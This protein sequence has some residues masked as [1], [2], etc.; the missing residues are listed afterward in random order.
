MTRVVAFAV[1]LLFVA[2]DTPLPTSV[3]V[4]IER[5]VA[6]PALVT[7]GESVTLAWR[8]AGDASQVELFRGA[9]SLGFQSPSGELIAT[10]I[11][12]G[13]EIFRLVAH[14]VDG[15]TVESTAHVTGTIPTAIQLF[16]APAEAKVGAEVTFEWKTSGADR[17]LLT[18]GEATLATRTGVEALAGT[19]TL[20]PEGSATYEL[21]AIGQR[22]NATASVT[23]GVFAP[24]HV[25]SRFSPD[26]IFPGDTTAIVWK[27]SNARAIEIVL[28]D[29]YSFAIPEDQVAEGRLEVKPPQSAWAAVYVHGGAGQSVLQLCPVIVSSVAAIRVL[30]ATP[31]EIVA[32]DA[33]SLEWFAEAVDVAT[34][35]ANGVDVPLAGLP[36]VTAIRGKL[37]LSP[38]EDTTYVLTGSGR[39]GTTTRSVLVTVRPAP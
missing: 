24:P 17:V 26:A 7:S 31:A 18:S 2:C 15:R 6:T 1:L 34:L 33:T 27:T 14:G 8:V 39:G 23:V 12:T 37:E 3:P 21:T 32:G 30:E 16:A 19:F 9:K 25:D 20:I 28:D 22:G 5:F 4:T 38:T 10:D 29:E 36:D 35:T 13:N 11:L